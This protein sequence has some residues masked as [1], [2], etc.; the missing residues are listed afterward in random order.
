MCELPIPP[1]IYHNDRA[2][3]Q[4]ITELNKRLAKLAMI[5]KALKSAKDE[6]SNVLLT[7]LEATGQKH[8]AYEDLGTFSKRT[9]VKLSLTKDAGHSKEDAVEWL[10]L[11]RAK[12]IITTKQAFDIFQARVSEEPVVAIETAVEEYNKAQQLKPKDQQDLIPPSPFKRF[13]QTILV[14]PRAKNS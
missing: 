1:E 8:L 2:C 10:E 4:F 11:C 12:G 6:A 5:E 13:E 7:R 9:S 3:A 14:T